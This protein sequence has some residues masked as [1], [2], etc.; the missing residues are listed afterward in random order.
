MRSFLAL[1]LLGSVSA[2]GGPLPLQIHGSTT[3]QGALE[4]RHADLEALVGRKIEFTANGSSVGL[5]SLA[6]GTVGIAM[7]ASPLEEVVA[8]LNAR[9]PGAV[10][11][12]QFRATLIGHAKIAFIVNPRNRV[13]TL[14]AAQLA[15]IFL[16]KTKNW[17][18]LGGT[19]S[20]I[21]IV[22]L[23]NGGPLIPDALL[24]GAPIISTARF[25]PNASQIPGV[26]AQQPG[27]I[28][29]IST[30]HVKGPTSLVQTDAVITVPLLLVTKGEP[31]DE[32][33][34]LIDAAKKILGESS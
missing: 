33:Q 9:S 32:E 16:G 7:I 27:A 1:L 6:A 15:D 25:V 4:A 8:K 20:A 26:V 14:S 10:D 18:E 21:V 22:S 2:L 28:G 23:A 11:I 34:K 13:R 29:I 24:H 31:R 12:S 30:V 19:D 17:K 3:V 5:A